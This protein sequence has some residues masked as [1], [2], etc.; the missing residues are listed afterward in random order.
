MHILIIT[1]W[2]KTP[3]SNI[4]GS[5]FEEQARA[6]IKKGHTVGIIWPIFHPYSSKETFNDHYYNDEGIHT[7]YIN[8]KSRIPKNTKL[9]YYLFSKKIYNEFTAKYL[10]HGTPDIIH[11]HTVFYAGIAAKYISKKTNIPFVITEHYTSIIT[12][13]ITNK[14]D[15][16]TLKQTYLKAKSTIIV[17]H[18]FKKLLIKKLNLDQSLFKVIPNMVS[19]IFLNSQPV[20]NE[21]I[22]KPV[23]FT[24]SFLNERK[25]HKL[26]LKSFQ[27]FL[28]TNPNATFKIGGEGPIKKELIDYS[29]ELNIYEKVFFL[30]KLDRDEVVNE[31]NSSDIFLLGSKFE[32]FGV[33]IIEALACGKPVITTNSTGPL[34]IMTN[35]NGRISKSF[36]PEDFTIEMHYVWNNYN[37]YI[38]SKI[39][40]D[41]RRRFS[42]EV[43]IKMVENEYKK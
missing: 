28:K 18:G 36:K 19:E 34:D 41:C 11:A 40:E 12:G 22:N 32:T 35:F 24:M 33:V 26:L 14:N 5:F 10:K 3:K 2:Y 1:S 37:K 6:L 27:L 30:G 39:K 23:F 38:P 31:M 21:N 15:I 42:E 20:T 8:Y 4:G 7:Y 43:I 13:G 9:N 16:N 25:N 17:S 29:K